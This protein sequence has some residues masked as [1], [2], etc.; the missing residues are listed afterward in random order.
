MYVAPISKKK[1]L[2]HPDTIM[3]TQGFLSEM[4][5]AGSRRPKY[6]Q[7]FM[8]RARKLAR[9]WYVFDVPMP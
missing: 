8:A 5:V 9:G 1:E 2:D 3:S 7:T 4:T 6:P